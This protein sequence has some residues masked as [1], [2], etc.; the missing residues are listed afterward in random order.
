MV[1]RILFTT[2]PALGH[3]HRLVPLARA[4]VAVGHTATFACAPSFVPVVRA[5][6]FVCIATGMDWIESEAVRFFP[7]LDAL[8]PGPEANLWWMTEIFAGT[9]ARRMAPDLL[10]CLASADAP[11]L[12]VRDPLEFG[13]CVAAECSGTP[14][15]SAGASV[16]VP[17]REWRRILGAPLGALRQSHGL[18]P[19]RA[20]V[21]PLRYLDLSGVPPALVGRRNHIAP[22][23]HFLR[24]A[25]I[26]ALI[27]SSARPS[28]HG[29]R[30]APANSVPIS[31]PM[32]NDRQQREHIFQVLPGVLGHDQRGD[33]IAIEVRA[34]QVARVERVADKG[35]VATLLKITFLTPGAYSAISE[36]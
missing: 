18:A 22:V 19:D 14:H 10:D 1:M 3:F 26:A 23:T 32:P 17:P 8:S 12:I 31:A 5:A 13:G 15:A 28:A 30:T 24:P 2:Q 33:D 34:L 27:P 20:V 6:G 9:T 11:D 35:V 29:G 36:P 4:A 21:M 16:F 7:E 25:P